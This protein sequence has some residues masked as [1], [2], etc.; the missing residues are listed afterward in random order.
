MKICPSIADKILFYNI[1]NRSTVSVDTSTVSID[2]STVSVDTSIVSVDTSTVSVD[3]LT[4]TAASNNRSQ[5]YK[6]YFVCS[7]QKN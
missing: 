5:C 1:V 6:I 4:V 2:T 7:H 3:T